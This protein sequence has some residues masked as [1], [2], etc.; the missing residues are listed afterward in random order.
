LAIPLTANSSDDSIPAQRPQEPDVSLSVQFGKKEQVDERLVALFQNRA[1]LKKEFGDL[2][3]ERDRLIEMLAEQKALTEREQARMRALEKRLADPEMGSTALVYYHLRSLWEACEEQL[4]RF[5]EELIKQQEDRERKRVVAEFNQQREKRL[6]TLNERLQGVRAESD[7][8]KAQVVSAEARLLELRGFWNYFRRR[9]FEPEVQ[10]RRQAHEAV[11]EQIEALLDERI[12]IESEPAPEPH[13][14]GL[15]G[16]RL[17]NVALIALAQ[18]LY[19]HFS[20]NSLATLARA[21]ML[22]SLKEQSYGQRSDCEQLLALVPKSIGTMQAQRG[23]GQELK[24]RANGLR[25]RARYKN[26][27]DAT[28]APDS[29]DGIPMSASET[30]FGGLVQVNVLTDNYWN[31]LDHLAR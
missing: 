6:Q 7:V 30:E 15:E 10:L 4:A 9:A 28:P 14:L 19:L 24:I 22:K 8:M 25:A 16:R 11:R 12:G 21:A 13:G 1:E 5:K 2:R 23:H 20:E 26:E 18:Y 17:I 29:V 27:T 3:A 31:L